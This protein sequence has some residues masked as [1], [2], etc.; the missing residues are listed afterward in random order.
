MLKVIKESY[1]ERIEEFSLYYQTHSDGGYSFP[2]DK[3]GS[4]T[5]LHPS[6]VDNYQRCISGEVKTIKPPFVEKIT[7]RIWHPK[8][9]ECQCGMHIDM[10]GDGEGLVYCECGK[11]Y[12]TFGQSVLPIS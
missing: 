9:C 7:R 10:Y 1:E 5:E 2:C 12:N 11:V 8:V 3:D 4:I 6:A